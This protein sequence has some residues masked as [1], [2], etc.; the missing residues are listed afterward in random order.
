MDRD[1]FWSLLVSHE[2]VFNFLF[3]IT[4]G[5]VRVFL[6]VTQQDLEDTYNPS[7]KSCVKEGQSS[8][9]MC[10]YNRVNGIPMCTD[11]ELLTLKVRNQW[12]FDGCVKPTNF[13]P[14]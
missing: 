8:S 12:G 4:Y 2:Y 14:P 6:Q 10:S 13:N 7:F 9:L 11:Y 3:K 5:I 1:I